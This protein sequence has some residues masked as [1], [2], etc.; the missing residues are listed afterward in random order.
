MLLRAWS[1][2]LVLAILMTV[3]VLPGVPARAQALTFDLSPSTATVNP[4]DLVRFFARVSNPGPSD[5]MLDSLSLTFL[6]DLERDEDFTPFF[7]NFAGTIAAGASIP[8]SGADLA[9]F[10]LTILPNAAPGTYDGVVTLN[11]PNGAT[12]AESTFSITVTS[13]GVG[14]VPE[15][16][17][18]VLFLVGALVCS[19]LLIRDRKKVS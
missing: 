5:V 13:V 8:A 11:D 19:C 16:N 9:I 2:L 4:G 6:P 14:A 3:L 18:A 1:L 15:G 12:L 7:D 10:D 17:S